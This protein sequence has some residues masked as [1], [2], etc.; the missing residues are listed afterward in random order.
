MPKL[1][2]LKSKLLSKWS[3]DIIGLLKLFYFFLALIILFP[4]Y[5]WAS[6]QTLRGRFLRREYDTPG[7]V[8]TQI[9]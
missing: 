7:N 4:Y 6:K 1:R 8:V 3:I 2:V 9:K 5:I